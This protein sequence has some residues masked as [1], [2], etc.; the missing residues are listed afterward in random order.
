MEP[1]SC[2]RPQ[3]RHLSRSRGRAH[4]ALGEFDH[5]QVSGSAGGGSVRVESG[6][7]TQLGLYG[8][9]SHSSR[10]NLIVEDE[11][12]SDQGCRVDGGTEGQGGVTEPRCRD[13][14]G[15][16][17]DDQAVDRPIPEELQE[18]PEHD[19]DG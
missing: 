18:S 4:G 3:D 11:A 16:R 2:G 5:G 19:T 14:V 13:G 12:S 1:Q 15:G 8:R 7:E 9:D 6:V 10:K 17:W